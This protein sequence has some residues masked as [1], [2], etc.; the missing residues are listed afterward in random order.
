MFV[1][2]LQAKYIEDYRVEVVFNDGRRGIADLE[3]ALRGPVFT[4]LKEKSFFSK[5]KVD[6]ELQTISWPNGADIAPEYVY[7]KSF[8]NEPELKS[9]FKAWGYVA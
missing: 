8:Q 2:I 9:K 4:P 7:F 6:K 5:L 3:D 1:H